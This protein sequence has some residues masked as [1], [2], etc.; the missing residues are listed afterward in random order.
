MDKVVSW[1]LVLMAGLGALYAWLT[2]SGLGF[3]DGHLT[4]FERAWEPLLQS[5]L[6]GGL[7]FT[8]YFGFHIF[9]GSQ[10]KATTPFWVCVV[11][12][13]LSISAYLYKVHD[14][15]LRLEHGQGG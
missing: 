9:S 7:A 10:E 1:I 3:P 11:V 8:A 14:Y 6:W 13:V 12:Y 4:E 15:G 5:L 2:L